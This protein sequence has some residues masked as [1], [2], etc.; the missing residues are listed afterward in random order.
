MPK[1][2]NKRFAHFR[3]PWIE[4]GKS[5]QQQ[6]PSNASAPVLTA[7]DD[8]GNEAAPQVLSSASSITAANNPTVPERPT[9]SDI[10]GPS[11][12]SDHA[13]S[14]SM[15]KMTWIVFKQVLEVAK[16]SSDPC[17]PLKGA[18]GGLLRV[19]EQ[20]ETMK[21][22]KNDFSFVSQKVKALELIVTRYNAPDMPE[23]V[24]DRLK[25]VSDWIESVTTSIEAQT[26]H[27]RP[28]RFFHAEED[29][30]M[31]LELLQ[32]LTWVIDLFM[33]DT[34]IGAEKQIDQIEKK[35]DNLMDKTL[36]DRLRYVEAASFIAQRGEFCLKGTRILVIANILR[37]CADD[38]GPSVYWLC[39]MAGTGKSAIT[40]TICNHLLE[41]LDLLGGSFFC[42]R[43]ATAEEQ[44]IRRIVP[45][46][47]WQLSLLNESYKLKLVEYLKKDPVGI[48]EDFDPSDRCA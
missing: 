28:Y 42:S 33:L 8:P 31:V 37:W 39:G 47:A 26:Q 25:G 27:S 22:A 21:D 43:R 35:I 46:L 24:K 41:N 11:R 4:P 34:N 2:K 13:G 15:G 3:L 44:D 10:L 38:S 17:P 12:P 29:R 16:E 7:V 40:R 45:T 5:N 30:K 6:I 32:S 23:S 20:Y 36:L 19:L 1:N 14:E 48:P 18:L 9:F